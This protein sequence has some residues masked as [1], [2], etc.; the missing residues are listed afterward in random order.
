MLLN[1]MLCRPRAEHPRR[2]PAA[3]VADADAA[4]S[5]RRDAADVVALAAVTVTVTTPPIDAAD[6]A[7][8]TA[9]LCG[10]RTWHFQSGSGGGARV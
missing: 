7:Q 1:T 5:R 10:A 8:T 9:E 4:T 3:T 2:Q 6:R